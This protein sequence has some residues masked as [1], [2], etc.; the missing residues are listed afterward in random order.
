MGYNIAEEARNR[1]AE[2]VLITGPTTLKPP[3]GV[4]VS[5]SK[6]YKGDV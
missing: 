5:K 6:Y 2:V 3:M 1:G 4:E